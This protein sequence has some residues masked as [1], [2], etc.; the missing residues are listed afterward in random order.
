MRTCVSLG[1][2]SFSNQ[3][4]K[5]KDRITTDFLV[6]WSFGARL[7]CV[8]FRVGFEFDFDV[9]YINIIMTFS[10]AWAV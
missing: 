2:F 8:Y 10:A 7:N 9:V 5:K 3:K 4:I 1:L 6:G